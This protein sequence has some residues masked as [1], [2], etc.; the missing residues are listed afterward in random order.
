[1]HLCCAA[2]P[3]FFLFRG[4]QGIYGGSACDVPFY[5]AAS[6]EDALLSSIPAVILAHL[7]YSSLAHTYF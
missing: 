2:P 1:M 5:F 3:F 7:F 4:R 6:W